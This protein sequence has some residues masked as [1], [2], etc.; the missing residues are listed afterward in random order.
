[1]IRIYHDSG[2]GLECQVEWE[3]TDAKNLRSAILSVTHVPFLIGP[4][5]I[6]VDGELFDLEQLP[7]ASD[8]KKLL[9]RCRRWL[10]AVE[11]AGRDR[12][13]FGL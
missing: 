6:E 3:E 2:T 1:M 12:P 10:Y 7:R 8:S 4:R 11:Q 13:V 9:D 5:V